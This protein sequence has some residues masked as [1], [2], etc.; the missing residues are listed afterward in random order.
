MGCCY[1]SNEKRIGKG[2]VEIQMIEKSQ[3]K[4]CAY[5]NSWLQ[6]IHPW[7]ESYDSISQIRSKMWCNYWTKCAEKLLTK[8]VQIHTHAHT[9][10]T[11]LALDATILGYKKQ[12][13]TT[14]FTKTEKL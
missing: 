11:I 4:M 3:T 13:F 6:S 12:T 5:Y 1:I 9:K 14:K 8:V 7:A 10:K 2:I